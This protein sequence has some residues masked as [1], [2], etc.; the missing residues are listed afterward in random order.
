M[1]RRFTGEPDPPKVKPL[2]Y[3]I[4]PTAEQADTL[5]NLLAELES[6]KGQISGD[7][8]FDMLDILKG[9]QQALAKRIDRLKGTPKVVDYAGYSVRKVTIVDRIRWAFTPERFKALLVI[10]VVCWFISKNI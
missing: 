9:R 5:D 3:R 7:D 4:D 10:F 2:R 6:V 1:A 8:Y